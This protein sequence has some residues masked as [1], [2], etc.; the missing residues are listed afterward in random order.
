M[1]QQSSRDPRSRIRTGIQTPATIGQRI[2]AFL[3]IMVYQFMVYHKMQWLST[4]SGPLKQIIHLQCTTLQGGLT[5][6]ALDRG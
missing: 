2:R 3:L 1:F 4:A 5:E 6:E